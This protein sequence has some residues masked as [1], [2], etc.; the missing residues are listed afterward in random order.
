[1]VTQKFAEL[2]KFSKAISRLAARIPA[3][4]FPTLTSGMTAFVHRRRDPNAAKPV[5][6]ED[7]E[8]GVHLSLVLHPL[9]VLEGQSGSKQ[10]LND[11]V[12]GRAHV[13]LIVEVFRVDVDLGR[14]V[15]V[16]AQVLQLHFHGYDAVGQM[17]VEETLAE[18]LPYLFAAVGVNRYHPFAWKND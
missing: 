5:I 10:L 11:T 6:R 9:Y 13:C 8:V 2:I 4:Y 12:L 14:V 16:A 15:C 18:S 3:W 1:M 17:T 7:V